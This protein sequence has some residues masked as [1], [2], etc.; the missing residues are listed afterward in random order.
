MSHAIN[1]DEIGFV[2]GLLAPFVQEP[3]RHGSDR[4]NWA[5]RPARLASARHGRGSAT[6][7]PGHLPPGGRSRFVPSDRDPI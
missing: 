6:A 2:R 5:D 3:F 4:V 1:E 7:I